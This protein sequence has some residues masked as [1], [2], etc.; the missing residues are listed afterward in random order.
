MM[1]LWAKCKKKAFLRVLWCPAC[2][3]HSR[4]NFSAYFLVSKLV[5]LCIWYFIRPP[6][7]ILPK[8]MQVQGGGALSSWGYCV[9]KRFHKVLQ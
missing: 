7:S 1:T 9:S 8:N 2:A 6:E 5:I 4:Y 3:S